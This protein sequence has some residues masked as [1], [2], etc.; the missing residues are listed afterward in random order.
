[1]ISELTFSRPEL[2][3]L[4]VIPIIF[5]FREWVTRGHKL[6]LPLDH[7]SIKKGRWLRNIVNS[8]NC[9]PALL[10]VVAVL[11]LAGPRVPSL[12]KKKR[13]MNNILFCVDVSGSMQGRFGSK[14][15]RFDGA[16][17]AIKQFINYE[18]RDGDA[19][20]LTVFGNAVLHWTTITKDLS[21]ID[22]SIPFLKPGTLPSWFGG[23]SIGNA[24]ESCSVEMEKQEEGDRMII[25]L[26]DGMSSD[27]SGGRDQQLAKKL[28]EKKIRVN[29]I[30]IATQIHPSMQIIANETKGKVFAADNPNTLEVVFEEIDEMQKSRFKH[31]SPKPIDHFKPFSIAGLCLLGLQILSLFGLRYTPW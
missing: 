20:G 1:M 2:L 5:A 27:L 30:S 9:M 17:R 15:N 4:L 14:G 6:V 22:Y 13:V 23:T 24:L 7:S 19:F 10:M 28:K 12:P 31:I 3:L 25:L 29:V 18:N 26:T 8:F 16:M 21:A 11:I